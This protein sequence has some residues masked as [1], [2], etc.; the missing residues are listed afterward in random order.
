LRHTHGTL[1]II[2]GA[3]LNQVRS[4][5]GHS[6]IRTTQRY[7]HSAQALADTAADYVGIMV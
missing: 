6:D 7:E 3:T 5:L 2:G 4:A 1:A